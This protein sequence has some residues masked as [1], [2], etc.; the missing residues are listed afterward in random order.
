MC[1]VWIES[2]T[3]GLLFSRSRLKI[4]ESKLETCIYMRH[5]A[6]HECSVSI[7]TLLVN[8]ETVELVECK[9]RIFMMFYLSFKAAVQRKYTQNKAEEGKEILKHF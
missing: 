4:V 6:L 1:N 5:T 8:V 7:N 9:E 3:D 2:S